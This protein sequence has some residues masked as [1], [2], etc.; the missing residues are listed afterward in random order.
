ML[1]IL[2]DL[3]K[4]GSINV[5]DWMRKNPALC[6][7]KLIYQPETIEYFAPLSKDEE[8]PESF[9][10]ATHYLPPF[11]VRKIKN[12]K[13]YTKN[14]LVLTSD[15]MPLTNYTPE[16]D[17]PLRNKRKRRFK[18]PK[19][20]NG[21]V[22]IF[23]VDP[24]NANY[25]HW[26]IEIFPKMHLVKESGFNVDYYV[27]NNTEPFQKGALEMFGIPDEK[28]INHEPNELIQADELI[29]P[30]IVNNFKVM[31]SEKGLYFNTKYIPKWIPKFYHSF[32]WSNLT[33]T[34]P[35]KLFV[36]RRKCNHRRI[37]NEAEVWEFLKKQG[38]E[39][40]VLEDLSFKEQAEL[41]YNSEIIVAPHG[42][43]LTNQLFCKP[44]TKVLEI[45]AKTYMNNGMELIAKTNDLKYSYFITGFVKNHEFE[46]DD[47][48]LVD[49]IQVEIDK[50]DGMLKFM[51]Q[52]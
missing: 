26:L 38:F 2:E 6:E 17:H 13:C 23:S 52:S 5:M 50:L 48:P 33:Q 3:K 37:V 29:V 40:C 42:A 21:S 20:I 31:L 45:F 9:Q 30:D 16:P 4:V 44:G 22:A 18:N 46:R 24:L 39:S 11:Y 25:F 35:K 49:D 43:G 15:D 34:T 19:K 7:E 1:S 32:V 51:Y 27:I 12:G 8:V 41:F 10:G 47:F 36:S 14:G 28:I